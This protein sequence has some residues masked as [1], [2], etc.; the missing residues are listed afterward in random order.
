MVTGPK[1]AC[2]PAT[3]NGRSTRSS[4]R[5]PSSSVSTTTRHCSPSCQTR[6][7]CRARVSSAGLV[8]SRASR[9][10]A[11]ARRSRSARVRS[12]GA[13]A[14]AARRAAA[15]GPRSRAAWLREAAA[16]RSPA[17][18]SE[19]RLSTAAG[20]SSA[21]GLR[22]RRNSPLGFTRPSGNVRRRPERPLSPPSASGRRSVL[23][24]TS[25]EP[26]ASRMSTSF[27]SPVE[28]TA[29][30]AAAG[31][32]P[33]SKTAMTTPRPSAVGRARRKASAAT[34][35]LGIRAER[36]A[37]RS[38][39]SASAGAAAARRTARPRSAADSRRRNMGGKEAGQELRSRMLPKRG[40]KSRWCVWT[41]IPSVSPASQS[42]I[43]RALP[44][45][46]CSAARRRPTCGG[47]RRMTRAPGV[48]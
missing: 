4:R 7:S 19:S 23:V 10:S 47:R 35:R 15:S 22:P 24:T 17:R 43:R 2:S 12:S 11:R 3:P 46:V 9:A 16:A 8:F 32:T 6:Q 34:S 18:R 37:A 36:S 28:V 38:A 27:R 25:P 42:Q 14:W 30:P 41:I 26:E 13:R 5:S 1:E 48:T 33:V 29:R 20:N 21:A 40:S 45:S 44:A 31:S 39:G